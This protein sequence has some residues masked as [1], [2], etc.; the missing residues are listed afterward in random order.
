MQFSKTLIRI[1]EAIE[2]D[3]AADLPMDTVSRMQRA[4]AMGFTIPA[5]H[6]TNAV[7]NAF[8]VEKG[9]VTGHRGY[10][11]Y[12]ADKKAEAAGYAKSRRAK[13]EKAH[14]MHVLLRV[15]NPWIDTYDRP[16]GAAEYK[17]LVGRDPSP[18]DLPCK[19]GW[20]LN[21]MMKPYL[22]QFPDDRRKAW[23]AIYPP[24]AQARLRR[25]LQFA[26]A[27]RSLR[28][29]VRQIRRARSE[30]RA[31]DPRPL[32]SGAIG[33]RRPD[34]L[35]REFNIVIKSACQRVD[36]GYRHQWQ[37]SLPDRL[38]ILKWQWMCTARRFGSTVEA[39]G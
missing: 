15:R 32:R 4:K 7:F 18:D 19:A 2:S 16:V 12:F 25:H 33:F 17:K 5:F 8:D 27:G 20:A 39:Y 37:D 1:I 21:D 35:T 30:E 10:A 22:R 36:A 24:S 14:V 9:N 31:L 6:G 28:R 23:S 13:G 26:D 34:G 29:H 38:G 11:P 3:T